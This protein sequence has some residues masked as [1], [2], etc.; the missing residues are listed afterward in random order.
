MSIQQQNTWRKG[1]K[2]E[3]ED[4]EECQQA[5]D[6][7]AAPQTARTPR[8]SERAETVGHL[9]VN[10]RGRNRKKKE[11]KKKT[12]NNDSLVPRGIVTAYSGRQLAST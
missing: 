6:A 5:N 1:E 8:P 9:V 12:L 3:G 11:A 10:S 7:P 2:K 4:G